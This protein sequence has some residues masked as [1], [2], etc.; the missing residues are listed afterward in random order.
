MNSVRST[1]RSPHCIKL[2]IRLILTLTLL[3]T[4]ISTLAQRTTG[5]LRGQVLDPQGAIVANAQVSITN[6]ATNVVNTLVTT[7]AGTYQQPSILPGQ[8]TV[9][10]TAPGFKEFVAKDVTVLSNQDNVADAQLAIGQSSETVEVTTGTVEVQTTSSSLDNN[11]DNNQILNVPVTGGAAYSPLNLAM[12]APNTVATP[13]GS[14]GVGGSVGGT[15]PRDNSFTVDGVDDNNVNV[16]GNNSTVIQDAVQEFALKT[17]QFSA[18]YG[19]SAGGQFDL[20]TKSGTNNYH[21]TLEGYFQNRNFNSLDNLTKDAILAKTPGLTTKPAYDNNRF[22]GTIGGPIIKNKFFV[23][24]AYEY[25]DLHGSGAPT[26]LTAPTASG[27]AT[28]QAMAAD[29]AVL[30]VLKNFPVAPASSDVVSVNG[31]DVPVGALTIVSPNLQ[32]E[33]DAQFNTDYSFGKHQLGT[34]FLYNQI[35]TIFPVNSTQAVFNQDLLIR[36]RKV[37]FNDVWSINS[38]WVNDLRLQYSYYAQFYKDPCAAPGGSGG[39]PCAPD[40]TFRDLGNVTIGPADNQI[41]K[42]NTYQIVDNVSWAHGKHTFKF[43]GQYMHII[44][45]QFFL[46]RSV[47][48]NWYTQLSDFIND[49]TPTNVGRTLR[50][51]GNGSFNGTQSAI[52]GFAQDDVKVTPRLTLNLGARYEFWTNPAGGNLQRLNAISNVPGVITFGVPK[53]DKNNIAPRIGFAYDPT[54][55]GRTAIRGGFGIA[56][57]VKFQNFASIDLPPQYQTEFNIPSS[58]SLPAPPVWCATGTGFLANGGL[59]TTYP[60][61][62]TALAARGITTSYVDDTVMPK[63]LTWSLGVQHEIHTN[64]TIEVRYLATRGLELPVQYRR[65]HIS[66]F[67]AGGTPLPTFLRP[68]DVPATYTASTPTDT[69]FNNFD[70]NAYAPYGF[71]GNITA[72]PPFASSIYHAGSIEFKQRGRGLTFDANYTYSHAI[73]TATNEFHTSELN[74][75][76]AQDSNRIGEDRGNS[77]VDVPHKVAISLAYNTPKVTIEN[78]F[79]RGLLNTYLVGSSFIAQSGQPVT[80]QSGLDSNGNGD[81]A[82][83]RVVFNPFGSG[84]TGSDVYAV[85]EGPGGATT[86][87]TDVPTSAGGVPTGVAAGGACYD[88]I[89]P[90]GGTFVPAI[91][92]TPVDPG[93]KYVVAGPGAR[94]TV[95][96]NSYRAPGFYTLNLSLA[97]NFH[98]TESKYFQIQASAFNVLNHPSYGLS[99]G[100]VFNAGGINTALSTQSYV[101]PND[102][103]FLQPKQF[104]GGI[105]SMIIAAHFFF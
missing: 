26:T 105:R 20:V 19:H 72:D 54:G 78:H 73:D 36:N 8:Y 75:R 27:L 63:I 11:F 70:S 42:Q 74:P 79:V 4:G 82:G 95:G 31:T 85:C 98:F 28:L 56:Y 87:S 25:T 93:A 29:S 3:L 104:G 30:N 47:G 45:P 67:D 69:A 88:A 94:T 40:V 84:R 5:T 46:S 22:G 92:Y 86:F 61:P 6:Q 2:S 33:H 89:D 58:C 23:F 60:P 7:S 55:S 96:R 21:G 68:S 50:G 38:N 64:S 35:K 43:G 99:N 39:A 59:P 13:G 12:L 14:Q 83:D 44:A 1:S 76:R 37:S 102:P 41:N 91:G 65:N 53:T 57:D 62:A 16:T 80:L 49:S 71:I 100:N 34:R 24:G 66:Y 90:T 51:A 32:K 9:T 18:E 97:R 81:S 10:V 103:N 17:N 101:L 77:D 15:R 52:Y 48:D